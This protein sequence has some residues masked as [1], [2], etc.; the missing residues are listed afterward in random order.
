MQFTS[1]SRPALPMISGIDIHVSLSK[2]LTGG[3]SN[4]I[5]AILSFMVHV[6]GIASS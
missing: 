3:T 6:I 1:G 2:A 5:S 4:T